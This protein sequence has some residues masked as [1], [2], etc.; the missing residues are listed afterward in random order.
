M[1]LSPIGLSVYSRLEHV[2]RTVSAL[3]R[4]YLAAESNLYIFSDGPKVGDEEKVAQVRRY[5]KSISGFKKINVLERRVN[6]R[7]DNN[8]D[9]IRYLLEKY[10][11][12]IYVEED[13]VT[14]PKFLSFMNRA[15]DFYEND[16]RIISITG[17]SPPIN[18]PRK[19]IQDVY[20]SPRFIAWGFGIWKDRFDQ[21]K[22]K[23]EGYDEFI[24]DR[25]AVKRFK[26]GGEDMPNM[27]E[28]EANGIIDA[29]D[30][31]IMFH[32]FKHNLYTVAPTRSLVGNIGIDGT[33]RHC[34]KTHKFDVTIDMSDNVCE[35]VKN[36]QPDDDIIKRL[37]IFRNSDM[38]GKIKRGLKRSGM[39]PF[40]K[41]IYHAIKSIHKR[42]C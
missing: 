7:V 34:G 37:Y 27:L 42:I 30:V 8:R 19:Y 23:I 5:L 10:N 24:N 14:A 4:N 3:Q 18:V 39:M 15:L 29:L 32:Q 41:G 11:R 36:I 9:G 2:K 33:G 16:S 35:M 20:L 13:I 21:I 6:S 1:E 31:K 17:Y 12:I 25:K 40:A 22:M 26:R 28:M 38:R